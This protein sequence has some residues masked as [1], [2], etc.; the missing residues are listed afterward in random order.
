MNKEQPNNDHP[1]YQTEYVGTIIQMY[2]DGM[3]I[4]DIS[5]CMGMTDK[6]INIVLDRTIPYL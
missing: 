5:M 6:V 3:A 2:I 1:F 4:E